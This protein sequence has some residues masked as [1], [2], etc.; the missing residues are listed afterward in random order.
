MQRK[1][2]GR[3]CARGEVGT[4]GVAGRALRKRGCSLVRSPIQ[5][6]NANH[7]WIYIDQQSSGLDKLKIEAR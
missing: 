1:Q 3:R 2:V 5:V 6:L 4:A 7:F